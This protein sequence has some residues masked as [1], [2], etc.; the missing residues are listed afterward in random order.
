ML[1]V[2]HFVVV[3]MRVARRSPAWV[4]A[5]LVVGLCAGG[6]AAADAAPLTVPFTPS[7]LPPPYPQVRSGADARAFAYVLKA[8]NRFR[9]RNEMTCGSPHPALSEHSRSGFTRTYGNPSKAMVATFGVLARSQPAPAA[10]TQLP[11]GP[12]SAV[13]VRYV[14]VAQHRF[15]WPF[16]VFPVVS[17]FAVPSLSCIRRE[18][19]VV[20]ARIARAPAALQAR[21]LRFARE[22]AR[23][24]Q[25][26]DLSPEGICVSGPR[27]T[28]TC[29]PL[30]V[31]KST[32]ALY[33]VPGAS[34]PVLFYLVP[35]G[36]AR[37]QVQ[38]PRRFAGPRRSTVTVPVRNNL[39]IWRPQ[40]ALVKVAP[41]TIT[42]LAGNGRT[43]R[44]LLPI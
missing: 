22:L 11:L 26:Q 27:R 34:N 43:L 18:A 31:A 42:W 35:N 40:E 16:K 41:T 21:A 2:T 38:Y 20:R 7:T 9:V 17:H 19:A 5:A 23:D 8:R 39:A 33:F 24:D 14:R 3:C 44:T 4:G 10:P 32:G 28:A 25:Y 15:G 12:G 30:P 37:I 6:W 29:V 13:F 36:V 1:H